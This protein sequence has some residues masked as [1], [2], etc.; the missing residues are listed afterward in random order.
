MPHDLIFFY[1]WGS[2]ILIPTEEEHIAFLGIFDRCY[3]PLSAEIAVTHISNIC[4]NELR[5][6]PEL[7]CTHLFTTKKARMGYILTIIT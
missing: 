7:E 5:N 1:Y 4:V 6:K 2:T 3:N